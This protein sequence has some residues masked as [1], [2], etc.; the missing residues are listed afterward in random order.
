MSALD[1]LA[2]TREEYLE[3]QLLRVSGQDSRGKDHP[4]FKVAPSR[5][6]YM[7]HARATIKRETPPCEWC[8]ESCVI[9]HGECHQCGFLLFR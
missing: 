6:T 1:G 3:L 2:F 7:S 4:I 5:E 9:T 8:N